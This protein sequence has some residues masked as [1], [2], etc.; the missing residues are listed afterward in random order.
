ALARLRQG[1]AWVT[2]Y[3]TQVLPNL[4]NALKDM[5]R[6]FV[7]GE[8]GVDL[9]RVNDVRR[10]LLTA[11]DAYLDAQ[12]EARQAEIDLAA[13]VGDPALA[14]GAAPAP[15]ERPAHNP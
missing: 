12:W 14:L 11:S 7:E 9:L 5:D 10:R 15:N 4:R 1:Q 8:R 2:T 6:L 13:A 3:A